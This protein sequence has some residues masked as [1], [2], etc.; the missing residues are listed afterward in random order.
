M[1]LDLDTWIISDTHFFHKN[2]VKYCDRPKD[3]TEIMVR[4]WH[5][6]IGD[7]DTVFHLGDLF[8]GPLEKVIPTLQSLPGN[9]Y[10][11][12][13]NHD[14]KSIYWYK[15]H[16]IELVGEF[17]RYYWPYSL[18]GSLS[19]VVFSHDPLNPTYNRDW[20]I[21]IHGHIHN[22]GYPIYAPENLDYRN[23]SIEVMDYKPV[24]L[25]DILWNNEFQS[26][27]EAGINK[28]DKIKATEKGI[29]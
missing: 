16:G 14:K 21:N 26:R 28:F 20:H 11:L 22:N 4:N 12:R 8:M 2:I 15:Q 17:G 19:Q 24:R 18:P 3:H 10:M 29:A 27:K 23:V 1:K 9:I 7:N 25:K 6:L 13:G 5:E